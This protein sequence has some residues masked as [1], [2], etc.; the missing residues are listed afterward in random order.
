L[1][2]LEDQQIIF[3]KGD[4]HFY[5][6]HGVVE[7]KVLKPGDTQ[8]S[9]AK[10]FKVPL[11]RVKRAGKFIQKGKRIVFR[12]NVFS[13]KRGWATGPLLVDASG[14]MIKDPRK[15]DR[16]YPGLNYDNVL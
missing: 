13:H 11:S 15:A 1:C 14:K 3:V 8:E 10:F 16:N 2:V 6:Q 7:Y 4:F 5:V 12:A 9:V